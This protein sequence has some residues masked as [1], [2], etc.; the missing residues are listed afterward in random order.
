MCWTSCHDMETHTIYTARVQVRTPL[1]G[2][3]TPKRIA[4]RTAC[5]EACNLITGHMRS[6]LLPNSRYEIILRRIRQVCYAD[7]RA[8][9][10]IQK[11]TA[12]LQTSGC[13]Q[14]PSKQRADHP[15]FL[16]WTWRCVAVF[17]GIR[18]IWTQSYADVGGVS[19]TDSAFRQDLR[20]PMWKVWCLPWIAAQ[21]FGV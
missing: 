3:A 14:T 11:D 21:N 13:L 5:D 17:R 8:E 7:C 18:R 20:C 16:L 9:P 15:V 12:A 6:V 1:P 19:D 2:L 10:W 4:S